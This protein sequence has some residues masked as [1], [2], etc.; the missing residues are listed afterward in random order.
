MKRRYVIALVGAAILVLVAVL[1]AVVNPLRVRV[2]LHGEADIKLGVGQQ[3]SDPGAS[4]HIGAKHFPESI[5]ELPVS[6]SGNVRTDQVGDTTLTYSANWGWWHADATRTVHVVDMTPPELKLNGEAVLTLIAGSNF[7]DPGASAHDDVDGDLSSQVKVSGAVDS[8]TPGKYV[9]TYEVANKSGQS[10]RLTRE[11][12]VLSP[13]SAQVAHKIVYLTFDDGPSNQTARLLDVLKA[14]NVKATFF[15]TGFGDPS[16]MAREAQEGHTV[17]IH[18][19]T[20]NYRQIYSSLDA[21]MADLNAINNVIEAQTGKRSN[22]VRL[23]GGSS[24]TVSRFNPGIMTTITSELTKRGFYY[25]DWNVSSG[26]AGGV[27]TADQ[28][29]SNVIQGISQHD[30]SM[31]LQHDTKPYSVDAVAR[32]IEWCLANG[33]TFLPIDATS[34]GMHHPLAN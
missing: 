11:V 15:V 22:L 21:Y 8:H 34:P 4:A 10:A 12:T 30:V 3:F 9:L 29:F 17:G 14:H 5:A 18:T 19:L 1:L 33:Y 28:V 26:D 27:H 7:V 13:Q 20:H 25:F 6:V 32:I 31:I 2:E 23:P 16:L 24:N